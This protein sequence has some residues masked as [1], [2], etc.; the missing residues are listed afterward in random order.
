MSNASQAQDVP[1][2]SQGYVASLAGGLGVEVRETCDEEF[3]DVMEARAWEEAQREITQ[4]ANIIRRPDSVLSMSCFGDWLDHLADYSDSNFPGDPDATGNLSGV[5]LDLALYTRYET[6]LEASDIALGGGGDPYLARGLYLYATLEI[7]V[8]DQ[9]VDDVTEAGKA[10]DDDTS[11]AN[12]EKDYYLVDNFHDLM[13]GGRARTEPDAPAQGALN[14]YFDEHVRESANYNGC[15]LMNQVWMRSKC[16]DF[17]TESNLDVH[18]VDAVLPDGTAVGTGTMNGAQEHDAF[19][20]LSEY[21]SYAA[22][23]NDYR[24]IRGLENTTVL[25]G[26]STI[27]GTQCPVPDD[28][29]YYDHITSGD[30]GDIVTYLGCAVIEHGLSFPTNW[31]SFFG[32]LGLDDNPYWDT[33]HDDANPAPGTDGAID[34]YVHYLE[35]RDTTTCAGPI[36]IGYLVTDEDGD[37]YIDAVCPTPGCWFNPPDNTTDEG[38]CSN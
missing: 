10:F 8:L 28:N 18:R 13:I 25:L 5:W 11:L 20:Q 31:E 34:S 38:T 16:Y 36:R 30:T 2:T 4:N 15:G 9:L 7:L 21:E 3:L 35:L 23:G 12:C 24:K 6:L 17:A 29:G 26:D 37:T 19:Y 1:Y 14:A 33:A 22:A 27:W 32:L